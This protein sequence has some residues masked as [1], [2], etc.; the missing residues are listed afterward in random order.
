MTIA[1][2]VGRA[3]A[4]LPEQGPLQA[5][6]HH[7]TLHA[8]EHLPF[9]DAV[10]RAAGVLGTEPYQGEAAFHGFLRSGRITTADLD[11]VVA[12]EVV[13]DGVPVVPGGPTPRRFHEVRLRHHVEVPRG[14]ALDWLLAETDAVDATDPRWDLLRS[15]AP[16]PAAPPPRPRPRDRVLAA[17]GVD[18]DHLAHPLLIRFTAAFL[19]QGV[20]LWPMPGREHGLLAAFRDLYGRAGGPPDPFLRGLGACLRSQRGWSAERTAEWALAEL[21][22]PG[23]DRAEVVTATL[24]SLR[25][26]AGMVRQFE[27]RPDRAPVEPRAARLVDYLAVQ[28]TLDVFATRHVLATAE[29]GDGVGRGPAGGMA[30]ADRTAGVGVVGAATGRGAGLEL[31]YEAFVLARLMDVPLTDRAGAAAW[32]AVVDRCDE[33]ERRRLLHLAYERRH[34]I[35]VLDGL[36]AHQRV[37]TPAGA[38]AFQA[39]FCLDEREESVRRHLEECC[40]AAETFG[41]AGFFGVAMHY[42]GVDD[43]RSRPLCPVVVTPRHAVVERPV[44]PGRPPRRLRARWTR[45]VAVGSR[46]LA[47]GAV[48]SVAL[49]VAALV[50]LVGRCLFPRAAHRWTR[51]HGTTPPTRLALGFTTAEQVDVVATLLRTTGLSRAPAPLVLVLGHGSSSLNNPHESAHDC[52]ATG[53]GRGGPNARAFAV[54]AN[55]PAV[56]S[57]LA[58]RGITVPDGTWFVGGYHNTCDDSITWYDEDL[59]PDAHAE[60]LREAKTALAEACV[61]AAHERCRRFETAP[62]D[63]AHAAAPAHAETHAVDLGQPRPEYGHA[64]NAVCVVGRRSRTRGLFLD[65]R[66]FLASYDPAADPDATLLAALLAAVGPVCAGINLEYYFSFV[67]PTGYGCGTKLPHNVTGL[68]GV[69]DGHASDLRTGL[70]WQMVEIHEPVR[71]LLVVEAA[72]GR[73]AAIVAANPALDRLVSGGWVQLVAWE[74]DALHVFQD[75]AFQPYARERTV[76]PVVA[77][78]VDVYAGSRDHLDCAHVLAEEVDVPVPVP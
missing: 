43:V 40:P 54:M 30:G 42:R 21:G 44:R 23:E 26:W 67:D 5:F 11:A 62:T 77:R 7:N 61:R 57:G 68:I 37:A 33:V 74:A 6:V 31:A 22:V 64:T 50:S 12:A 10:T 48:A 49:G 78:S 63:L 3:A 38:V 35:G 53:G 20:A 27:L 17:T 16:P 36:A 18:P 58:E 71:L 25:G 9:T 72:P 45:A 47:G 66:A 24:L 73:L 69:M 65:R 13:D 15:C 19:D 14:P 8:F 34:R 76:F 52:G 32:L 46:T 56:R 59:V 51:R 4:L 2:L 70:P 55:D 41:Y 1:E 75:G 29:P 39:V 28:L 60:P